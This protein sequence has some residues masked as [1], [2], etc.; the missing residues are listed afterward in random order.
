M[1]GFTY[2]DIF[3]TKGIEYLIIIGFFAVL[4]PFW[5]LLTKRVKIS[6]AVN[7]I[8]GSL[9][10]R[11][12]RIPQGIFFSGNHTWA[13]LGKSG[14][15]TI[16]LDDLLLHITGEV[17]FGNL[18]KTG[19][20]ISKGELLGEISHNGNVL[21]ILSP[22]SGEVVSVNPALLSDP[23]SVSEDPYQEGW[24]Y[25]IRPSDW[26]AE[27]STYRLADGASSWFEQ[28]LA[29]FRDFLARQTMNISPETSKLILQDG[30]EISDHTLS[31]LPPEVWN[32]FQADF[33]SR[34]DISK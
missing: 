32:S 30:G 22:L 16:G 27:T 13:H 5:L 26:I 1:D 4:I 18:R 8:I 25:R 19:E 15:A 12:L 28:E 24:M 3:E 34:N 2:N 29:R 14:N 20:K 33:L 10:M 7:R 6:E 11:S 23:A 9:S 31:E 21:K 17:S